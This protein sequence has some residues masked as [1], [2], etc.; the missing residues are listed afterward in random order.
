MNIGN[1]KGERDECRTSHDIERQI[2]PQNIVQRSIPMRS[3][4]R[5]SDAMLPIKMLYMSL[6]C[7][8]YVVWSVQMLQPGDETTLKS[9]FSPNSTDRFAEMLYIDFTMSTHRGERHHGSCH[10]RP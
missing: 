2:L 7:S 6:L 9:S 3:Q 5:C 10:A 4:I 8:S 1:H